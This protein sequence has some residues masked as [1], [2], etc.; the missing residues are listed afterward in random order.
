MSLDACPNCGAS[1]HDFT[2]AAFLLDDRTRLEITR[3]GGHTLDILPLPDSPSIIIFPCEW[4]LVAF[5]TE[6]GFKWVY[7]T[8]GI[9]TS[10]RINNG[11]L[12]I[13]AGGKT[14]FIHAVT[15]VVKS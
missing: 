9:V 12:E 8:L 6:K 5:D 3:L 15:G 1:G 14:E 7:D 2:N 4:G 13:E 11:I 10:A